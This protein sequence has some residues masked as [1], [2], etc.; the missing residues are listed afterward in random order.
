MSGFQTKVS[1]DLTPMYISVFRVEIYDVS[2]DEF[3]ISKRYATP[4]GARKMNG[5]IIA[6]TEIEIPRTDL[7]E[8]EEWT[9]IGYEPVKQ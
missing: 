4:S 6:N 3:V 9:E 8:G 1:A 5:R 2:V 7:V